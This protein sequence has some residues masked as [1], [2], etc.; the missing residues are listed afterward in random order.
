[1]KFTFF[2]DI[3]L[4]YGQIVQ[5]YPQTLTLSITLYR[6]TDKLSKIT[7]EVFFTL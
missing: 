4:D 2:A 7:H 6:I 5:Q 3:V 1:M